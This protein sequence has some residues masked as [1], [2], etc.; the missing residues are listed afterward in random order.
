MFLYQAI[1]QVLQQHGNVPMPIEEIA[2]E[3]N[4]KG[5]CTKRDGRPMDALGVGF[6]AVTDVVNGKPPFFD[7][8]I[9]LSR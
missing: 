1:Q 6:R 7:V 5:L 3:I 8:L 9:R 4:S 2:A